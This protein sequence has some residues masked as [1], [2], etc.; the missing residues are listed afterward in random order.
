MNVEDTVENKTLE[1]KNNSNSE[2]EIKK[3]LNNGG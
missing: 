3:E 1:T 2:G